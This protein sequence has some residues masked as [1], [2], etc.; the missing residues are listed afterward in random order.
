MEKK[1]TEVVYKMER[2]KV[3][4]S[5]TDPNLNKQYGGTSQETS[6]I[7]KSALEN[8]FNDSGKRF[9][10]VQLGDDFNYFS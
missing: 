9:S 2:F 3:S 6:L 5:P 8:D 7:N 1:E 4:L 10:W